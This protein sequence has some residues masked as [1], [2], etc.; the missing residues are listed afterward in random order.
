MTSSIVPA[1]VAAVLLAVVVSGCGGSDS[2]AAGEVREAAALQVSAAGWKT[3]FSKHTVPLSEFRSGGPGRDGIPP[4]D[5]P[6]TISQKEADKFLDDREPVLVVEQGQAVRAYPVQ[7]LIWHEIVNDELGGRPIAVTYCPLCNSSVV[8][9][10]RVD[11][12]VLTF[13]TTGNLRKSDLVMWDRQTESWWQQLSAEA[14]VG[15]LSGERL[16]VLPS[17]T[18]SWADFRRSFA[19]G[20]VLSRDTGFERDYGRNPYVGY[21][22]RDA[23][24]F[25]LDGEADD[26]LPAKEHVIAVF[27]DDDRPLVIPFSRLAREPAV[28]AQSGG[29]PLVALYKQ[30]VVSPLDNAAISRSKDVGTSAAFDRRVDG[31]TLAFRAA[32][33]RYEDRQTGSTWDITGRAI[34]GPL[35]G[36]RLR[37]LRHDQQFWFAL[38]AFLPDAQILR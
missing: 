12:R 35:K 3:D 7:I 30:G 11:D 4:I 36:Q 28:N 33:G 25:L 1:S 34:K 17:Q 38:A 22:E 31:R 8:F 16:E 18:L 29:T 19:E 32:G 10:R 6:R 2:G 24:P 15:E 27:V 5:K 9:D 14:V 21:D 13:G 23:Q 26:R 20:D 37:P